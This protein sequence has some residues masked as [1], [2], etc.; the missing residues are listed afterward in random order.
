LVATERERFAQY[1]FPTAGPAVDMATLTF[2]NSLDGPRREV[3]AVGRLQTVWPDKG[4]DFRDE[5]V[6]RELWGAD[7]SLRFTDSGDE[8]WERAYVPP[9]IIVVHH[10]ATRNR[11]P[12]PAADIRAIYAFH[13]ITQGWG[14]IG[15][16][17]L[18]DHAGRIY[19]GRRGRDRDPYGLL[20]RD[21]LSAG[22]V[23]GHALGF[24]YGS[25]GIA[26]L[27]NFQEES[28]PEP[29]W[30]ALEDLLAF[31]HRRNRIDP[32][33]TLDYA[34]SNDLWR[35]DLPAMPGHRDCNAT[36]CPGDHVYPLL[37]LLRDRV[38]E[39]IGGV[40]APRAAIVQ[41]PGPHHIW[42]GTTA[43]YSWAGR[44]PYDCVYE[45]FQK[46][47]DE[48]GVDYRRGFDDHLMPE[49]I[50]TSQ[51]TASFALAEP[52]QYT[53]HIQPADHM[54]ADRHTVIADRQ[55]VRDNSDLEGV[56]RIGTWT[57]S[58]S[59]LEFNGYDYEFASAGSQARFTWT[60]SVPYSGIYVVQACWTSGPDRVRRAPYA[61]ARD[62]QLL[63]RVEVDQ[64]RDGDKWVGLGVY[65]FTAGDT[66]SVTASAEGP[67]DH[68]HVVI[69]DAV[70]LL[71]VE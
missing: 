4:A 67:S 6:T 27:G 20:D 34:R 66:C 30:R 22:V 33:R 29:M 18:I 42:L 17:A 37:P 68:D 14:D 3:T 52:G 51:N 57:R 28:P 56:E 25:V 54:F 23:G 43:S 55:V 38:A 16:S 2:L 36:E 60:L 71:L 8:A 13:A 41:L 40:S 21:V 50:L 1:R 70:R 64:S 39:R 61:V 35:Y 11:P 59:V 10:T 15:Y 69:A 24:N 9:R 49:H 12:D 32:R 58:R 5:V 46:R 53:L 44:P 26:L 63:E 62:G 45:G 31:E 19:E 48:D 7:E 65:E 47:P